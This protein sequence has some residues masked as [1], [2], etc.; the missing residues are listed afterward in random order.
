MSNAL[1][2]TPKNNAKIAETGN[3]IILMSNTYRKTNLMAIDK[4]GETLNN[5]QLGNNLLNISNYMYLIDSTQVYSRHKTC[6]PYKDSYI[7]NRY[8]YIVNNV[9]ANT[10][11][12]RNYLVISEEENDSIK[13]L[14][15]I[16]C[17]IDRQHFANN[18]HWQTM[19]KAEFEGI[20][21]DSEDYL[22]VYYTSD[23]LCGDY[24]WAPVNNIIILKIHKQTFEVSTVHTIHATGIPAVNTFYKSTGYFCCIITNAV[25]S[26]FYNGYYDSTYHMDWRLRTRHTILRVN[27]STF[28]VESKVVTPPNVLRRKG[29][30]DYNE[31][32]WTNTEVIYNVYNRLYI[33]D[34]YEYKNNYYYFSLQRS[35]SKISN[36][37]ESYN[38]SLSLLNYGDRI[39]DSVANLQLMCISPTNELSN[40][41]SINKYVGTYKNFE[42]DSYLTPYFNTLCWTDSKY[43]IERYWFVGDYMYFI[44]YNENSE[45]NM[46][47]YQ[48]I[49][50]MQIM[51]DGNSFS[52]FGLYLKYITKIE[53]SKT[54]SI[55]SLVQNS[56]RSILLIGFSNEFEIWSLNND[57]HLY[58]QTGLSYSGTKCAGF[59]STD[60]IWYITTNNGVHY[61]NIDDPISV[62]IKFEKQFYTYLSADIN[63]YIT[64]EAVN[65]FGKTAKGSYVLTLTGP[66]R[67]GDNNKK[68]ITINYNGDNTIHYPI[69][70]NGSETISCAAKFQKVWEV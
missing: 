39:L 6:K 61:L 36:D 62:K 69:V 66:A 24:S 9:Y 43:T 18:N 60:R 14:K 38:N 63:S 31:F 8:Y 68:Q 53:I 49:H 58:E 42:I 55:I 27:K 65:A 54:K 70:I 33:D 29:T 35:G 44:S 5:I 28:A 56:D 21:D 30:Y 46:L 59:D 4:E 10:N 23:G 15:M 22:F 52:A 50:V 64:F 11:G 57:T 25:S 2:I 51:K 32:D 1:D 47:N 13:T 40:I 3:N 41:H 7:P 26:A 34:L 20:I 45:S 37:S 17:P 19:Y 16:Q 67:F 12:T 48:Q